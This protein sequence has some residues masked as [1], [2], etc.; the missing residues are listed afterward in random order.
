[1]ISDID[2]HTINLF[3]LMGSMLIHIYFSA[4]LLFGSKYL[5]LNK[6]YESFTKKFYY[7]ICE[8]YKKFICVVFVSIQTVHSVN[9][10]FIAIYYEI[11]SLY[12]II[13]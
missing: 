7:F 9:L 13:F 4:S 12:I 3:H 11:S 2:A 1:L 6:F 8:T 5:V 10:S